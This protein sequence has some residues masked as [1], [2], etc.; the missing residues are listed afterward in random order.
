MVISWPCE[1]ETLMV[2]SCFW[3]GR[4]WSRGWMNPNQMST[5]ASSTSSTSST[6]GRSRT[7]WSQK[8]KTD[9]DACGRDDLAQVMGDELL[10]DA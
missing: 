8:K 5:G 3:F 10:R 1:M 6:S 4:T 7:C 2:T 9:G